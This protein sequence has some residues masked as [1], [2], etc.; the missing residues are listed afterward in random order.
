MNA[1]PTFQRKKSND[2]KVWRRHTPKP[3]GLLPNGKTAETTG[4]ESA[5]IARSGKAS[6]NMPATWLPALGLYGQDF[7]ARFR[8]ADD[9]AQ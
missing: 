2:F 7:S 9:G 4:A 3:W 1:G 6:R 5:R 8:A